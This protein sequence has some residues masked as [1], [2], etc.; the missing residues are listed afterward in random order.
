MLL[1]PKCTEVEL[2]QKKCTFLTMPP[3]LPSGL[4]YRDIHAGWRTHLSSCSNS[5]YPKKNSPSC[6]QS[7]SFSNSTSYLDIKIR[8]QAS[9]L[10]LPCLA[11]HLMGHC[12]LSSG[13]RMS[14]TPSCSFPFCD[15]GHHHLS[16]LKLPFFAPFPSL[17]ACCSQCDLKQM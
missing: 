6:P 2:K 7:C 17:A 12:M 5:T 10:P 16:L 4:H 8:A 3:R 13:F 11:S 15:A 9:P 1:L 14:D